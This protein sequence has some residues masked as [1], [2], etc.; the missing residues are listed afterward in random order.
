MPTPAYPAPSFAGS[1]AA[2]PHFLVPRV[3]PV[4]AHH[5]RRGLH[6]NQGPASPPHPTRKGP[7]AAPSPAPA[8][9]LPPPPASGTP[10]SRPLGCPAK[11]TRPGCGHP[12]AG[13]HAGTPP[14]YV[15]VP[16]AGTWPPGCPRSRGRR[17]SEWRAPGTPPPCRACRGGAGPG[18]VSVSAARW[19]CAP[20]GS[21]HAP[22]L[23][24]YRPARRRRSARATGRLPLTSARLETRGSGAAPGRAGGGAG[25]GHPRGPRPPP[26]PGDRENADRTPGPGDPATSLSAPG[27]WAA[28]LQNQACTFNFTP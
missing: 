1:P 7:S 28:T 16:A 17:G 4:G 9:R 22:A 27:M 21:G 26:L 23:L 13:P 15:S 10:R 12:F 20:L 8:K 19:G 14:G 3:G 18:G 25:V 11:V 6:S 2:T 5:S 24:R